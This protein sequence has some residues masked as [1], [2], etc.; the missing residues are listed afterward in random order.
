MALF[1]APQI[2]EAPFLNEEES[3]H[4]VKVLRLSQGDT[5]QVIDG[6]G[7]LYDARI[8][9][10]SPKRVEVEILA[11][12][13]DFGSH[14]YELHMAVAPTKNIDR[15]EWFVEKAV[16][17]GVDSIT[18]LLCRYSE[19]KV[20]KLER[21]EKIAISA[22][23]Q[24]LKGKVPV[25]HSLTSIDQFLSEAPEGQRFIAHCHEDGERLLLSKQIQPGSV[26]SVL[27]G[28]EGDFSEEEVA[29]A[30]KTG[31]IPVSL[32]NSRLRTETAAV[33]ATHTVAVLNE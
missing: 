3:L 15:F 20:I 4:C 8:V 30:M 2:A 7:T 18:P 5:I 33:V 12:H 27:I 29:K 32:G 23:K 10:P 25:I 17:I 13:P 14:P 6:I 16:E 26:C 1:F 21:L 24:S 22:A 31:F 28:P 9:V 19:R 11:A